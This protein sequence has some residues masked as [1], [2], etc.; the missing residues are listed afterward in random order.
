LLHIDGA[1]VPPAKE[2]GQAIRSGYDLTVVSI[3]AEPS[4]VVSGGSLQVIQP[5]I[6]Y[7]IEAE[8]PIAEISLRDNSTLALD[9]QLS[10]EALRPFRC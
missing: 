8:C 7:N 4:L 6:G 5:G 3:T 2:G 10:I 9:E 1:D